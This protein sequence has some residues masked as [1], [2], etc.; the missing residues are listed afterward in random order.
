MSAS[1]ETG[2][3]MYMPPEALSDSLEVSIEEQCVGLRLSSISN[4]AKDRCCVNGTSC[5]ITSHLSGLQTSINHQD[6]HLV[7]NTQQIVRGNIP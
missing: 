6:F 4:S 1:V 3:C 2:D 7:I 5:A